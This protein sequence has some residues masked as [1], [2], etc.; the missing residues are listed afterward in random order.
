MKTTLFIGLPGYGKSCLIVPKIFKEHKNTI[1]LCPFV[2][3]L[4]VYSVPVMTV[5]SFLVHMDVLSINQY[6]LLIDDVQHVSVLKFWKIL[7]KIKPNRIFLFGDVS[8]PVHQLTPNL[9]SDVLLNE[10]KDIHYLTECYR[11]PPNTA[12]YKNIH[13]KTFEEMDASF[14]IIKTGST[15]ELESQ[16]VGLLPFIKNS[17][18]ICPFE[19]LRVR[20]NTLLDS[21]QHT[22]D[23]PIICTQNYYQ[24]K[25]IKVYASQI[26]YR[27]NKNTLVFKQVY[28]N[29]KYELAYVVSIT[30]VR[31]REAEFVVLIHPGYKIPTEM[32]YYCASRA[33][34]KFLLL[35]TNY[36]FI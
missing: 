17:M 14:C 30:N 11:Y 33:K 10:V 32:V 3:T 2:S 9:L 25:K 12:L 6:T 31:G 29:I 16:L 7:N 34:Q 35:T 26:G 18:F 19:D 4:Q 21:I 15:Q 28:D 23:T 20:Y 5:D 27:K 36:T 8:L 24:G 22:Q 1:L 13:T